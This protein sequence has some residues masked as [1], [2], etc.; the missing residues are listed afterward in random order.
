MLRRNM[1][2][3]MRW[4]VISGLMLFVG[5]CYAAPEADSSDANPEWCP[6]TH[7]CLTLEEAGKID[8]QLIKLHTDLA[9][10]KL[11]KMSRLGWTV[12]CG[13]AIGLVSG[14]GTGIESSFTLG[15]GAYWG[16][17]F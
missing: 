2:G 7:V 1:P 5:I 14:E 16:W 10:F 6:D 12:G 13:P 3:W 8:H 17:R 11:R 15:C 9:E 4:F